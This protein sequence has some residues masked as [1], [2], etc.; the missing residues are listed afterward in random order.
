MKFLCKPESKTK[1]KRFNIEKMKL[2]F[3]LI[4]IFSFTGLLKSQNLNAELM[5]IGQSVYISKCQTCHQEDGSGIPNLNPPLSKT[6]LVKGSKTEL[7]KWVL[8]GTPN[9]KTLLDGIYYS[10]TMPA[11]K[12]LSNEELS[13]VLTYIRKSFGNDYS[14]I[15]VQDVA[16][17]RSNLKK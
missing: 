15:S 14:R 1:F 7:I 8:T 4:F 5:K 11:Q 12:D 2:L 3:N 6:S 17:V 16:S 13:A 9:P 10:N